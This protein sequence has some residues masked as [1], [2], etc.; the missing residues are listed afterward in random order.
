M[1]NQ[2]LRGHVVGQARAVLIVVIASAIAPL[3][4][5]AFGLEI[6]KSAL[7]KLQRYET[8][9]Y[10][11]YTDLDLEKAREAALRLDRMADEYRSRTSFFR[12]GKLQRMGC[13]LF[14][15]GRDFDAVFPN[16][17]KAG[18]RFSPELGLLGN[19]APEISQKFMWEML[20]HEGFHQFVFHTM[21]GNCPVWLNE[22]LA[23]FFGHALWT[24]DGFVVG[25]F[26]PDVVARLQQKIRAHQLIE[27]DKM[28][29]LS[30]QQWDDHLT[31]ENYEQAWSIVH[32]LVY[33]NNEKY[34]PA[35]LAYLSEL[36]RGGDAERGL[37]NCFGNDRKL[38]ESRYADW[39]L[40]Q[41]EHF[42][43][44]LQTEATVATLTSF[45]ARAVSLRKFPTSAADF[46]ARAASGDIAL[47]ATDDPQL[48]LPPSLLV[49]AVNQS[50][51]MKSWSLVGRGANAQLV[52]EL[53]TGLRFRGSFRQP[54][55]GARP[56]IS[57]ALE[58]PKRPMKPTTK[59]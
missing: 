43:D 4:R 53:E 32:F 59:N 39:W 58:H 51:S 49:D 12:T 34:Q 3:V 1:C 11:L 22:G 13:Y 44:D 30:F 17:A 9:Y 56:T 6:P 36:A 29:H 8:D 52:L 37:N 42:T 2:P 35:L 57:V 21:H 25:V 19:C 16:L 24:G 33:A 47:S 26:P 54:T 20:Q 31:M 40:A 18:G 7:Q 46:I 5:P 48:W 23:T 10:T 45:L 14:R 55:P 28:L 15:D 50:K 27:L 41:P 38:F